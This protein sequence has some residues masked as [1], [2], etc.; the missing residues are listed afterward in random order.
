M[1]HRRK[2][3]ARTSRL[4]RGGKIRRPKAKSRR[5]LMG[6][7]DELMSLKVRSRGR[8]EIFKA[9]T[10]AAELPLGSLQW[11]HGF[12]RRYHS[13]RFEGWN[14][15]SG[16]AACH[17]Y[18]TLRPDEWAAFL[19]D[20]WGLE[21]YERRLRIALTIAKPDVYSLVAVTLWPDP[22]VQQALL[23]TSPEKQKRLRNAV[24][25]IVGDV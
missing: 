12:S 13:V 4:K 5:W 25:L 22:Q 6:I 24:A 14:A 15:F 9:C 18:Y 7:A 23:Q 1:I 3:I 19:I 8:C 21:E 10:G 17:T 16:C 11:C 20:T 2:P